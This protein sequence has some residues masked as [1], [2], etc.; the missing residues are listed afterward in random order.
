MAQMIHSAHHNIEEY[1]EQPGAQV[2]NTVEKLPEK[3]PQINKKTNLGWLKKIVDWK[4]KEV[5]HAKQMNRT[6][7][8]DYRTDL[9]E[10]GEKLNA[11][12]NRLDLPLKLP[13][14]EVNS[15]PVEEEQDFSGST[16]LRRHDVTLGKE[17]SGLE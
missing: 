14:L 2:F 12:S 13:E 7:D 16:N 10:E 4:E 15:C 11:M 5:L 9:F 6:S 8:H 3:R 17:G 1:H